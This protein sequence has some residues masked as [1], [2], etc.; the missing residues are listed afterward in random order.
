MA[1]SSGLYG[2]LFYHIILRE[3]I[4]SIILF[5]CYIIFNWFWLVWLMS[6][7]T[8]VIVHYR[9]Y[10]FFL[11]T[12]Y[13]CTDVVVQ[14]MVLGCNRTFVWHWC[15]YAN[16][17]L[18]WC[19]CAL[20]VEPLVLALMFWCLC[21][22]ALML[23]CNVYILVLRVLE[24]V[25]WHW[26]Y[27]AIRILRCFES[28]GYSC[29]SL[30]QFQ[31]RDSEQNSIPYMWEIVLSNVLVQGGIV[32]PDKHGF[33]DGS[34]HIVLFSTNDLKSCPLML[35]GHWWFGGGILEKVSSSAL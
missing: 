29:I 32:N 22:V 18:H 6:N 27:Y 34:C 23:L 17:M 35:Y 33:L 1:T 20:E 11:L 30:L 25:V 7:C 8:D 26:C 9:F 15:Y 14:C 10:V 12:L 5:S 4:F 19:C 16:F 28:T 13:N 2:K 31:F 3:K 24:P 21:M